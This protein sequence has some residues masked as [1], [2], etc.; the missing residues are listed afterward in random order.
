MLIRELAPGEENFLLAPWHRNLLS[1]HSD[2][3]RDVLDAETQPR[4]QTLLKRRAV[5]AVDEPTG[6]LLGGICYERIRVAPVLHFAYVRRTHR[7]LGV[8]RALMERELLVGA[9]LLVS[10]AANQEAIERTIQCHIY[11]NPWLFDGVQT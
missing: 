5:V 6:L 7:R 9:P 4:M 1:Q 10:M 3:A 11:Y 8:F 2:V